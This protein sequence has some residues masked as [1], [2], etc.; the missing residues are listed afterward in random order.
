M[1]EHRTNALDF[2]K[3]TK[4]IRENLPHVNVSG[5]VSNVSFLFAATTMFEEAMHSA[6][7]YHAIQHGMTMGIVNQTLL[8]IYSDIPTELLT[9]IEDV[10]LDR[11]DDATERLLNYS[12]QVKGNRRVKIKD[13]LSWRKEDLQ[14]RITHAL[15]RGIDT[16]L[17]ED[18]EEARQQVDRPIQVIEDFLMNG[19]NVV[20]DFWKW[21]N[22]F[23]TSGQ[24]SSR[25]EKSSCLLVALHRRR[26]RQ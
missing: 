15:V 8:E 19:M 16:H 7:L 2:F 4:W 11:R 13:D 23:A 20:G 17:D 22:V 10:L 18:V 21:K 3:A 12:E 26:K 9:H 5:G 14:G 1:E 25:D 24:I 6:F